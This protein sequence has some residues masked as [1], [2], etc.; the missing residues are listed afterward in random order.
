MAASSPKATWGKKWARVYIGEVSE[1]QGWGQRGY[2]C[3]Q[4]F[5]RLRF[6]YTRENMLYKIENLDKNSL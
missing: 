1:G 5:W 3:E 2:R 4:W 6:T